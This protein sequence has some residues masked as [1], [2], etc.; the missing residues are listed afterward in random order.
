MSRDGGRVFRTTDHVLQL[1][2]WRLVEDQGDIEGENN[3]TFHSSDEE[4]AHTDNSIAE[5]TDIQRDEVPEDT[6][7]QRVKR[8][9]A[10]LE[11][12]V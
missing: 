9:P 2:Q 8:R 10:N 1:K 4:N 6:P 12:Y 3:S 11:D 5:Q 7:N